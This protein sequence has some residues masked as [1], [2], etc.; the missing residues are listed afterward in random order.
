[1]TS[2]T[3][4]SICVVFVGLSWAVPSVSRAQTSTGGA[5]P[6]AVGLWLGDPGVEV[7]KA[8][9]NRL[10]QKA[11]HLRWEQATTWGDYERIG[12]KDPRWDADVRATFEHFAHV[13]A[14]EPDA[15]AQTAA[16]KEP[17]QRALAAGCPDPLL[18]YVALRLGLYPA[19]TTPVALAQR[20]VQAE[21][22]MEKIAYSPLRKL[23][24]SF[25]VAEQVSKVAL[26]KAGPGAPPA[27]SAGADIAASL[28]RAQIHLVELL[29][30][31]AAQRDSVFAVADDFLHFAQHVPEG[32]ARVFAPLDA[33]FTS[34]QLKA[35]GETATGKLIEGVFWTTYAWQGR[36]SRWAKDVADKGWEL[37]AE[38]LPKAQAALEKAAALDPA[39]PHI[40]YMMMTVELGQGQG[41]SRLETWFRR[42]MDADP[43]YYGACS[44]KLLYL[45]PKWYGDA[46]AMLN[47]GH[48]CQATANWPARL[49]FILLLAHTK[50]AAY[51]PTP[52]DYWKK[53][54]VWADV[55]QLY[56]G[57]LLV[58][59][60]SS[61][62]RSGYALYA[63]RAGQWKLADELFK[64]L[65][66]KPNLTAMQCTPA[67]Y[68]QMR[69]EAAAHVQ[70]P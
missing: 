31:P 21:Q 32:E 8:R 19:G 63:Y 41:R 64:A 4:L 7:E 59:P 36:T 5:P 66:D 48:Q 69:Q 58:N 34:G 2:S 51:L 57:A 43:D 67:Q 54:E 28:D 62:D 38:R 1:M 60:D 65:G 9:A 10:E 17:C 16:A 6:A 3:I 25:R 22:A 12:T 35:A 33:V 14:Q 30:D 61:F 47:F 39:D 40:S 53:P 50:L 27:V 29:R 49:P 13:L 18:A 26:P 20:Y 55:R 11:A 70:G 52:L 46:Q 68:G 37:F 24:A 56:Q 15:T 23:Y 42:A 44:N 45:E